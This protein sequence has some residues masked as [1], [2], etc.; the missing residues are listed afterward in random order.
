MDFMPLL[1]SA[2]KPLLWLLPF[3][4]LIA[5][6]KSP[7]FKGRMGERRVRGLISR[8]LDPAIYRELSDVT[9]QTERGT[10]QIDH[11][12]VSPFGILV[13][14]TKCMTGWI[15]GGARQAQW[16][17]SIYGKKHRFQNPLRQNY[18]HIKALQLMLHLPESAFKSIVVFVGDCTLKTEMPDEVCTYSDLIEYIHSID[19]PILSQQQ[20]AEAYDTIQ[21]QRLDQSYRTNR[22]H[23]AGLKR[24]HRDSAG[25]Q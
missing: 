16:T 17:Q 18:A 8:R 11:V 4:V 5:V 14:E 23:V 20:V 15:F 10:T 6:L 9:L 2:F 25:L 7:W 1:F 21:T 22:E 3:L 19:K 12:Y 24:R 13:I